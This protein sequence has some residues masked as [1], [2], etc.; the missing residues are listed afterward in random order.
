M[1]IAIRVS[2]RRRRLL[3]ESSR[4]LTPEPCATGLSKLGGVCSSCNGSSCE[5]EAPDL[6][7]KLEGEKH[8]VLKGALQVLMH[9]SFVSD[10]AMGTAS[11]VK[12]ITRAS[13]ATSR[14]DHEWLYEKKQWAQEHQARSATGA[15]TTAK[16]RA[17]RM[18]IMQ[19]PW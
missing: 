8:M 19:Q 5:S 2:S 14:P 6:G 10:V 13:S 4:L 1:M 3:F 7:Y 18:G 17:A 15:Y 12:K 9:M 16:S 11:K